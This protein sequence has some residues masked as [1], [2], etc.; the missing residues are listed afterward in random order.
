[1]GNK[2]NA[3]TKEFFQKV[4]DGLT[5]FG[6]QIND[7]VLR[8]IGEKFVAAEHTIENIGERIGRSG[9][10]VLDLFDKTVDNVGDAESNINNLLK[11]LSQ[12]IFLYAAVAVGGLIVFQMVRK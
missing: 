12:P 1:M 11:S 5:K 6:N 8:P 2:S 10:K 3:K 7:S 4:G 9:E